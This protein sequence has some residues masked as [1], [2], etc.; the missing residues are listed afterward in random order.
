MDENFRESDF[1]E[2]SG[3]LLQ[4]LELSNLDYNVL[5]NFEMLPIEFLR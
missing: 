5:D 3:R 2:E 1:I 4:L